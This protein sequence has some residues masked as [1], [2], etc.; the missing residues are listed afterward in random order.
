MEND[1]TYESLWSIRTIIMN[2]SVVEM[3]NVLGSFAQA[4][5]I[6]FSNNIKVIEKNNTY[7]FEILEE[8][9][10]P[11]SLEVIE[12]ENFSV[13]GLAEVILPEGLRIIGND[14][15]S[16]N[17]ELETLQL[18]STIVEIGDYAFTLT[19]LEEVVLPEG[20]RSLGKRCFNESK[21]LRKVVIPSTLV[22]LGEG[23]FAS[24]K[25]S[26][27]EIDEIYAIVEANKSGRKP[28]R[29]T[30]CAAACEEEYTPSTPAA[31]SVKPAA[32]TFNNY[33]NT[34]KSN[35]VLPL[36]VTAVGVTVQS[37]GYG[38]NECNIS[39]GAE[40]VNP[41]PDKIALGVNVEIV[42][43]DNA[44]RILNVV[45]KRIWFIDANTTFHFGYEEWC[46][47]DRISNFKINADAD[48]FADRGNL[49]SKFTDFLKVSNLNYICGR[50]DDDAITG[51]ISNLINV[52]LDAVAL[53]Y[54]GVDKNGKI[55]GGN[56]Q[57]IDE[58]GAN[59]N[60]TMHRTSV[61]QIKPTNIRYSF[62]YNISDLLRRLR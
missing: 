11:E 22:E 17:I 24:T 38:S 32:S 59:R 26:D 20:L 15:F 37:N 39:F 3:R 61:V 8:V 23:S 31:K 4:Y 2:D 47:D 58:F 14:C 19:K 30:V 9:D 16:D 49:T 33:V 52:P 5:Y 48:E 25:F 36:K 35:V 42:L 53:Y 56:W 41:N 29:Y 62:D 54:H 18:P 6:K 34:Q 51:I 57:Y 50:N 40:I 21:N 55:L 1:G 46:L 43:L 13:T 27:Q 44:G 10:F 28:P 12:D 7:D 45:H 60:Y